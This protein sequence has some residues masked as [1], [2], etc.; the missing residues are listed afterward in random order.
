MVF[1][2]AL[3]SSTLVVATPILLAGTGEL[4]SER[5]GVL[6]IGLEGMMLSG[7]FFAFWAYNATGQLWIGILAGL[8][9]GAALAVVMAAVAISAGGDQV[10]AG[11]G[12]TI[13][14][15][16]IT[17]YLSQAL[18]SNQSLSLLR[19][20][21]PLPLPLLRH[22]PVVGPGLF[23]QKPIVYAA[24]LLVPVAAFVLYRTRWGLALRAAG[25]LPDAVTAYGMSV[26]RLRYAGTLTAGAMAGLAG[27]FLSI[28]QVGTFLSGMTNGRGYL[29]LAAVIFGRWTVRGVVGASLLFG[30]AEALELRLQGGSA[31]PPEVWGALGGVV[32]ILV[33]FLIWRHGRPRGPLSGITAG[34][35]GGCVVLLALFA[36]NPPPAELPNELWLGLP[37]VLALV[38]MA[39]M[40]RGRGMPAFLGLN[41]V[42]DV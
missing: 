6:N 12:V 2:T 4:V 38:A 41:Y 21:P 24:F 27:A 9:G 37:Y 32:L 25:D 26:T 8:A 35:A 15:T 23:S 33:L 20:Q 36:V 40:R 11:I 5:S 14:G 22:I 30:A 1:D 31:I 18:F 17:G 28:G 10:V 42:E 34:V 29:A 16:G 3:L 19:V 7:A 13:L 39:T